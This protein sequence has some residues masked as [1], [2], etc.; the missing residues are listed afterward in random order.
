MAEKELMEIL[1]NENDYEF[2]GDIIFKDLNIIIYLHFKENL[3]LF[4]MLQKRG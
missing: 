4:H 1:L 3:Y 2:S